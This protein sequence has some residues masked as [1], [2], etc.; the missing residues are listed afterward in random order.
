MTIYENTPVKSPVGKK[1]PD[2]TG[3][4]IGAARIDPAETYISIAKLLQEHINTGSEPA[5]Q[6]IRQLI[7]KIYLTVSAALEA[8]EAESPF[9]AE[10]KKQVASGKKLFFKPNVV[11]LPLIDYQ[12]HGSGIPG[13]NTHWEFQGAV[14]RWFHDKAGISFHQMAVG[15]AGMTISTDT[16]VISKRL[17]RKLTPE[18][19]LEGKY[20][21]DYGGWGF[22]FTRKYLAGCH[23]PEHQDDP[24]S[25]YRES[26]EG[27][28]L[29]PGKAGDKLMLYNLNMMDENNS[30]DVPVADGINYKSITIHKAVIGGD[31]ENRRDITD[32]PGCVLVNLP[33]LKI[34]IMELFTFALKNLGMGIFAMEANSSSKPGEY[35][36][37]YSTPDTKVPFGKLKV[38]HGRWI[39]QTD[40][41]T[42]KPLRD[43][44]GELLWRRTGGME[45]TIA[46]GIQA[47]K[48]QN[49]MMLHV[50]DAIEC[51][52]IFHSGIAGVVVPEGFVF[53]SNDPV[54]LDNCGAHYLFNMVPMID[55][56]KIQEKYRIKSEVI[57]KIPSVKLEGK[58]IETI[59]GY[60]S[61]YSRYH[62]LKHCEERGLG[63]LNYYI[64]GKDL[65]QG[66][67]LASINHHLGR[68][69]KDTFSDLVTSTVYRA[70]TKPL[71]DF[72]AG[73]MAYLELNDKLTGADYKQQLLQ[74]HDENG[75]GVIDYMEGGKNA[76]AMAGFAYNQIL[77][78]S[79]VDPLE[80]L[81]LRFLFS[82][83]PARWIRKEWNNE[84]LETGEQGMVGQAVSQAY[85]MSQSKEE[86]PDTLY[87]GRVWGNGKWPSVQY[88]L[89]LMKYA[90]VYGP[91]FPDRINAMMSP[92]GQAFTYADRKWNGGK[93]SNRQA[94]GKNEDII[95]DYHQAVARGEELL[96]FT[97]YVPRG[98]GSY[99]NRQIPNVEETDKPELIFSASF[100]EDETWRDFRL[101]DYP[102][103]K[104]AVPDTLVFM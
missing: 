19:I 34:H 5:W 12:T 39:V 92:Y 93:Y 94:T 37:K 100:P 4:A 83:V 102:W 86:K 26:L 8:L 75:D 23:T 15:E 48:G 50:G 74:F 49:I 60:D 16:A 68:V 27:I 43:N 67:N 2:N 97:I 79:Q 32:W 45:A 51:T 69:E 82:M 80:A 85:R 6:K 89:E 38:P 81:K 64:S 87:K 63:Q 24:F 56:G 47:V 91:M 71:M 46:D 25:G 99:N 29:P 96:P 1:L 21:D 20:G 40:E 55:T 13:A 72:Q 18:A 35:K 73:M 42:L 44:Q 65:W 61:C 59:A 77:M 14:M 30:R 88:V 31:P 95:V 9:L 41:D 22:Y 53:A 58:N 84:G 36:W 54:A 33:L 11:T 62:A 76:G 28:C 3:S 52:N 57:Q 10:V 90:R 104:T 103:L 7:D 17:G 101:S 98:Y 70:A 78:S 66:G